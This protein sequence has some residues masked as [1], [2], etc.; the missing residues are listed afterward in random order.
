MF[1]SDMVDRFISRIIVFGKSFDAF[2]AQMRRMVG[3]DD[4]IPDAL[5]RFTRP[6]T[7]SYFWCPPVKD[8]RLDLRA[9]GI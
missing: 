4:G 8:G 5:F 9:I 3:A 6:V 1:D 2:E 7:G